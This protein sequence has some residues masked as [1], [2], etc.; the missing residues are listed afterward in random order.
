MS[1][2]VWE[3]AP[4]ADMGS[5][6]ARVGLG[7]A[8]HHH[9]ELFQG[10]LMRGGELVSCLITMPARGM[11]SKAR[12]RATAPAG[13]GEAGVALEVVPGWKSKAARAAR[14]TLASLGVPAMGRLEIEC[15]VATGVG[16]GSSTCDVVAAIR[17]VCNAFDAELDDDA[18]ARLTIEAEG[19]ADPIMFGG[20]V[21]LFAQ[22]Q[23][24]VLES[25]GAWIP[26]YVVLSVDTDVGA[27]GVD[28]LGLPVPSYTDAELQAFENM[29]ARMREAFRQQ[30]R[31]TIAAVARESATLNQRFLPMRKFR[32]ICAFAD[33][34]GALGLQIS[35]SGTVAGVLFDIRFVHEHSDLASQLAE[36]VR[37]LGLRPLGLFTSG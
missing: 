18:V 10:A 14:L 1:E 34:W 22:R 17:A 35:H 37:A 7:V 15:A 19:A 31:V 20:N 8:G 29:V 30:D 12:F 2:R 13:A 3:E 28:T 25:W 32:E 26:A 5:S 36:R 24:R 11:G 6:A 21:V 33:D 9:G 4:R 27:R 23:G 16:L